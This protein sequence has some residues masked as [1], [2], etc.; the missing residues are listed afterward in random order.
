MNGKLYEI[1]EITYFFESAI[2]LSR[3]YAISFNK[4]EKNWFGDEWR[5][6]LLYMQRTVH[7]TASD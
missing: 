1:N 2:V 7:G 5:I 3:I 4:I 6:S